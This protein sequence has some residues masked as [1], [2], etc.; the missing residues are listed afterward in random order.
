MWGSDYVQKVTDS[1]KKTTCQ[2]GIVGTAATDK[3]IH[4]G[5]QFVA[6]YSPVYFDYDNGY[7]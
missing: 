4:L 3:K 2:M 5:A 1:K 6:A 7:I